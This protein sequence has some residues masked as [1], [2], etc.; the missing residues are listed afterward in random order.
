[1]KTYPNLAEPKVGANSGAR[2]GFTLIELL[3]VIAIVA[4]LASIL[5][6]VFARARENA[7][8]SSCMSNMKQM[9]L[10]LIQYSQDYDETYPP[11][12]Y[13]GTFDAGDSSGILH[14]SGYMQP[15]LKS[16]QI[17][18]CPG[19][20]TGGLAPTNY[21]TGNNGAGSP[22]GQ[23]SL[24]GSFG[25]LAAGYPAGQDWQAA[26]LSYTANE[27]I[28]P[29]PRG[30]LGKSGG[31]AQRAVKLSAIDDT[32]GTIAVT[33]FHNDPGYINGGGSSGV[34]F[35]SHRPASGWMTSTGGAVYDTDDSGNAPKANYG[36]VYGMT[37]SIA[38]G[39]WAGTP[40]GTNAHIQ[41]AN[42]GRHLDTDNFLFADGHAKALRI[43]RT[44]D[45]NTFM[46]GKKTYNQQTVQD[47][48]CADGSG[49]VK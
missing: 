22:T 28:L 24:G 34:A 26:R 40:N 8:R 36:T 32:S 9:G 4:I 43:E 30:S 39:I 45:C 17:F 15:Y 37:A 7:R 10:G 27:A 48:E 42:P 25:S 23:T 20:P 41:Y 31:I 33:E 19:D 3:V 44:F 21:I 14:W 13:Y 11:S 16:T 12:Y 18:V 29:R 46:W 49:P 47:V 6:P 2:Q 38:K 1:M 5:F 35:K